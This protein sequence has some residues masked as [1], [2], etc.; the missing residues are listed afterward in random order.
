M[1]HRP[2]LS[3][4]ISV[5]PAAGRVRRMDPA[6][7][8]EKKGVDF[9]PFDPAHVAA[10]DV[11]AGAMRYYARI[12]DNLAYRKIL[13]EPGL[14]WTGLYGGRVIGCAGIIKLT[15]H[16]GDCWML[17]DRVPFRAWYGITRQMVRVFA[18]AHASGIWRLEALVRADTPVNQNFV[19]KFGFS[20]CGYETAAAEDGSDMIRY[21]RVRF[22]G[23]PPPGAQS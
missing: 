8:R 9:I 1:R 13:M 17:L 15:E 11:E 19:R 18:R 14:A 2:D 21:E 23:A 12:A 10:M 3:E 4:R 20:V 6:R 7:E 22:V 5:E 16:K